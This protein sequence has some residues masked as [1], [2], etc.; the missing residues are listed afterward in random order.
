MEQSVEIST[1]VLTRKRLVEARSLAMRLWRRVFN[2]LLIEHDR[3]TV[4]EQRIAE[5]EEEKRARSA[6]LALYDQIE[7][8]REL[9]SEFDEQFKPT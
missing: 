4:L 9:L 8:K 6:E 5:L 3:I 1:L 2:Q 7:Q